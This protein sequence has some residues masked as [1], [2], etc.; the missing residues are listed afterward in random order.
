[1]DHNIGVDP[2]FVINLWNCFAGVWTSDL[3]VRQTDDRR[4]EM[5]DIYTKSVFTVIAICL[6]VL[7]A[8]NA[9]D[10]VIEDAQAGTCNE[11]KIISRILFC[12]DGSRVSD[13]RLVTYC[14]R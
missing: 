12:L 5:K 11:N 3:I 10:F 1:M 2:L 9:G 14:N 8:Q 7:V 13:G 6:C 4:Y